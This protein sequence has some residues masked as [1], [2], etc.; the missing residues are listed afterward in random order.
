MDLMYETGNLFP[1]GYLFITFKYHLRETF[2]IIITIN[3][4][5]I[6]KNYKFLKC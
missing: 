1:G 5:L 6:H 3:F 2:Y 4:Y